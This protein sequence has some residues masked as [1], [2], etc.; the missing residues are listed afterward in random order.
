MTRAAISRSLAGVAA[1]GFLAT[2]WL[3]STGY[4]SVKELARGSHP[5]LQAVAPALWLAFSVDLVVVGLIV[6]VIAIR[7]TPVGRVILAIAACSPLAG[8]GL[9]LVFIGF[10]P[11]TA[12]L[13][14]L[15]TI[16]LLAAA[17]LRTDPITTRRS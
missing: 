4:G 11:P 10:V 6:A 15:G 17:L 16:T 8:A 3:H 12:I 5:D 7:P 1:A 14:V 2:A 13:L 9:Q